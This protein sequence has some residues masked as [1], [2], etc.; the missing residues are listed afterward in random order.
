MA[1]TGAK[2]RAEMILEQ[3]KTN[4]M[5]SFNIEHRTSALKSLVGML[6][7]LDLYDLGLE[8][9]ELINDDRG[10]T[11]AIVSIVGAIIKQ[12]D[13]DEAYEILKTTPYKDK[14]IARVDKVFPNLAIAF[15]EL[16]KTEKAMDVVAKEMQFPHEQVV[17]LCR[18]AS[19]TKN[20]ESALEKV[21]N[22]INYIM[23]RGIPPHVYDFRCLTFLAVS[24]LCLKIGNL[25][26]H[27]N[28]LKAAE[29][30]VEDTHD[31][32]GSFDEKIEVIEGFLQIPT[33]RARGMGFSLLQ[34]LYERPYSISSY[35]CKATD[36]L[37]DEGKIDRAHQIAD[38]I[39]SSI[40]EDLLSSNGNSW[41][42]TAVAIPALV[43]I[44]GR[45]GR[46]EEA[47]SLI[48][49]HLEPGHDWQIEALV[50]LSSA[51]SLKPHI[52]TGR[53]L[54]VLQNLLRFLP[55]NNSDL[56]IQLLSSFAA[57]M[58]NIDYHLPIEAI[59]EATRII[60]W[61]RPDWQKVHNLLKDSNRRPTTDLIGDS[62]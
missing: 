36:I 40:E 52:Y 50:S 49:A 22:H 5:G 3:A 4:S 2:K 59:S 28:Y 6:A 12:G 45:L 27:E 62:Y 9:A 42:D 20:N 43:R 8:I 33:E 54:Y 16:G 37:I 10:R 57:V 24:K 47:I 11:E 35:H 7:D 23:I 44:L 39:F 1:R 55:Q 34:G 30:L 15:A 26:E 46:F 41:R 14:W 61:T 56:S 25:Q 19:A 17:V 21:I 48:E 60:G 31:G 38:I 29:K 32:F 58:K 18:V 53:Y 13:P 51:V